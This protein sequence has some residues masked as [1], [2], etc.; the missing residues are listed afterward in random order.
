M[1]LSRA[2]T[3]ADSTRV[4][5][6]EETKVHQHM[7]A[8]RLQIVETFHDMMHVANS[9]L[10]LSSHPICYTDATSWHGFCAVNLHHLIVTSTHN[11]QIIDGWDGRRCLCRQQGYCV[12]GVVTRRTSGTVDNLSSLPPAAPFVG[13]TTEAGANEKSCVRCERWERAAELSLDTYKVGVGRK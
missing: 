5:P 12:P 4:I 11:A 2:R 13:T 8:V 9:M 6:T 3:A 1:N 7:Y 10:L